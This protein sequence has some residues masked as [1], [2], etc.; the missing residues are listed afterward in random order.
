MSEAHPQPEHEPALI[1]YRAPD[2]I[3]AAMHASKS[4]I[5]YT[6]GPRGCVPGS[7]EVM[8][9]AGWVPLAH[10]KPG[11]DVLVATPNS[12][13]SFFEPA[14]IVHHPADG[15]G[16]W[17]VESRG[18]VMELSDEHRVLY[19]KKYNPEVVRESTMFEVVAQHKRLAAGWDG[20]V[21]G[22]TRRYRSESR[23]DMTDDQIRLHVAVCADGHIT[24]SGGNRCSVE[25][26]KDRKWARLLW[27]LEA[28]GTPWTQGADNPS[29]PTSR[30]AYFK[31]VFQSRSLRLLAGAD[32]AQMR[33]IAEE[34][35]H[36]DGSVDHRSGSHRFFSTDRANVDFV[37]WVWTVT[38]SR[39]S[40]SEQPHDH[41]HSRCWEV[42]R[43]T[44]VGQRP[45]HG[46]GENKVQPRR[47]RQDEDFYCLVTSTGA[48]VARCEDTVFITGNSG[49][50]S[51]NLME[52]YGAACTI[53]P[54]KDGVRRSR[55][56]IA[57]ES[58]PDLERTV[59]KTVNNWFGKLAVTRYTVPPVTR[60]QHDMADGTSVECEFAYMALPDKASLQSLRSFELTGAF[61]NEVIEMP[62]G[63]IAAVTG[64]L[65]RYPSLTDFKKEDLVDKYGRSIAPYRSFIL[66]DTNPADEDH[67][68]RLK[69]EDNPPPDAE[70]FI[71]EGAY[72]EFTEEH[73]AVYL[74]RLPQF[75]DLVIPRFG[76]FYVPNPAATYARIVNGGFNYWAN[77]IR[78][79]ESLGDVRTLV[80]NKWAPTVRGKPVYDRYDEVT[81]LSKGDIEP[82]PDKPVHIGID[83]SGLHPAAVLGQMIGPSLVLTDSLVPDYDA[84]GGTSFTE[85]V[86]E[87]L[88]PLLGSRYPGMKTDIILDPAIAR[89]QIDKATV[90]DVLAARGLVGRAA[91]TNTPKIRIDSVQRRMNRRQG[92]LIA[93]NTNN[94]PLLKAL[95]GGYH[96]PE[97]LTGGFKP[98]PLK[99]ASSHVGDALGYLSIGIEA[100][101]GSGTTAGRSSSSGILMAR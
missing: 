66:A 92:V 7:T 84:T 23:L 88:L 34:L 99:N 70:V 83:H 77:M 22:S 97:A 67:Q 101:G 46:Q 76:F 13:E 25:V 73:L 12:S 3:M 79:A 63:V 90:Y 10:L 5:R 100:T 17:R 28:T 16:F 80:C 11:T 48:W 18:L 41:G 15:T 60:I 42:L 75:K 30:R 61:L 44:T 26:H 37:Q 64:S 55:W 82:F 91:L 57:R 29:R 14:N 94:G 24:R 93:R 54:C 40:I 72:L 47:V 43:T 62:I 4:P 78:A 65:G 50:S 31:P 86:D 2:R 9:R 27:L 85:F 81:M 53:R 71:Q 19:S 8:T 1:D 69:F 68:W 58:Y 36:W 89:S 56:L 38:G 59:I 96:Y 87:Y 74:H 45:L 95:R 33:V 35:H 51:S 39:A 49:K 21:S 6:R 52:L 32:D 20:S 98:E